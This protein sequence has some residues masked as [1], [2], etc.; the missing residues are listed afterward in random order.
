MIANTS[1]RN[2]HTTHLGG[3]GTRRRL[4]ASGLSDTDWPKVRRRKNRHNLPKWNGRPAGRKPIYRSTMGASGFWGW[5]S[6]LSIPV[7]S[8]MSVVL[9]KGLESEVLESSARFAID[10]VISG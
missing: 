9:S 2:E 4:H 8:P 7:G 10:G 6:K 1:S 5:G 3:V